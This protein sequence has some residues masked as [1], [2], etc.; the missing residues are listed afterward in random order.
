MHRHECSQCHSQ[1]GSASALWAHK[2]HK[3]CLADVF[4]K[5]DHE[6]SFVVKKY[7]SRDVE[8]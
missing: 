8:N 5:L 7:S 4:C 6:H 3:D 2:T 1:L